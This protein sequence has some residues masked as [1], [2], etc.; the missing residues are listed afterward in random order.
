MSGNIDRLRTE[1]R[2]A[3]NFCGRA[4][5]SKYNP[6]WI[7]KSETNTISTFFKYAV[8]NGTEK[9]IKNGNIYEVKFT[10]AEGFSIDDPIYAAD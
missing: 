5:M 3:A 6:D 8:N 1:I 7:D 9:P 10:I 4:T 2:G